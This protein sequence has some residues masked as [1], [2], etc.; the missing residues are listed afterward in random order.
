MSELVRMSF[1]IEPSLAERLEKLIESSDYQNRSE[2][3][4]DMIRA[5]V[6]VTEWESDEEALGTVT[7]IYNHHSRL[8]SEKLIELQHHYHP[9][10]LA[11]THVHLDEHLCAE[12]MMVKGP[13]S[14]I[15][16]L[17]NLLQQ[18]KGVLHAI[19]SMTSTGK[20]LL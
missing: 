17:T 14:E 5:K 4:R 2:F 10:V 7:L 1:S 20:K 19:L 16:A 8:L 11:T 13:A 15:R 6:V 3:I 9:L 18:Q 12:M